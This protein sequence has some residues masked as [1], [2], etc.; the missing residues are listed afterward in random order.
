MAPRDIPHISRRIAVGLWLIA[1]VNLAVVL[2]AVQFENDDF[3]GR[4]VRFWLIFVVHGFLS[5]LSRL[6]KQGRPRQSR[7]LNTDANFRRVVIGNRD[8]D[9]P[10]VR[11]GGLNH[12]KSRRRSQIVTDK[13]LNKFL[14]G[15]VV[16]WLLAAIDER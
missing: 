11:S 7:L 16:E 15:I 5:L 3:I 12:K 4:H 8:C 1:S 13:P 6:S 10:A 2:S 14:T 9:H